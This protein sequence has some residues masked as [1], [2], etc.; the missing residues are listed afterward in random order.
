MN[1]T[2]LLARLAEANAYGKEAPLPET[3]WTSELALREIE[4]RMGMK[5]TESPDQP[6]VTSSQQ[7][8]EA[9]PPPSAPDQ[10]ITAPQQRRRQGRRGPLVA[11]AAAVVVVLVIGVA[12]A[13]LTLSGEGGDDV[14][15]LQPALITS[16][17]DVAGTYLTT[18]QSKSFALHI[19]ETGTWHV[20]QNPFVVEELPDETYE[21]R[22]EGTKVFLKETLGDCGS[23]TE[24]IYEIGLLENGNLRIVP[25]EDTCGT[26]SRCLVY[27]EFEPFLVSP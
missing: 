18:E 9:A 5:P 19:F 12:A 25:I 26:R 22:F 4:R 13:I 21:T 17:E 24:A 11:I 7:Q 8:Q 15:T 3:I 16:F 14:M 2:Q 10:V 1:D 20:A 6:T 23:D 27:G